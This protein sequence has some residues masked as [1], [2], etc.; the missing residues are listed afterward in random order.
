MLELIKTFSLKLSLSLLNPSSL[1]YTYKFSVH[2]SI[3]E[4]CLKKNAPS[5][6]VAKIEPTLWS[7][8]SQGRRT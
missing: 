7:D 1:G 5:I 2:L 3:C 6:E 8:P 4:I